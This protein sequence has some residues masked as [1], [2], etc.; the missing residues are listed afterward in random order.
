MATFQHTEPH[1]ANGRD[2]LLEPA[3]VPDLQEAEHAHTHMH[4][5]TPTHTHPHAC[6][7]SEQEALS[8]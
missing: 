8:S 3:L 5:H 2:L 6:T 7:L 1:E 4:T